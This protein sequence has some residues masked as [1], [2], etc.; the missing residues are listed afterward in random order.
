[1]TEQA[2]RLRR[3]WKALAAVLA[4]AVLAFVGLATLG[5]D[6][7][8]ADGGNNVA[9]AVN[10]KDGTTRFKVRLQ[11]RRDDGRVVD[12]NQRGRG[13]RQL[14]GLQSDRRRVPG[15]PCHQRGHGDHADEPLARAERGLQRL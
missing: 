3:A 2:S 5:A 11:I 12:A 6:P 9:V 15:R 7:A 13:L 1:M 4:V 14:H 10:T 8:P